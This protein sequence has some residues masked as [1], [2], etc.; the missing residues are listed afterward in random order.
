MLKAPPIQT[1]P[2][3]QVAWPAPGHWTYD[4]YQRLPDDGNRYEVIC[5]VL[6]IMNTPNILHQLAI[7]NLVLEIGS[8]VRRQGLGILLPAP[9]EVILPGIATPAQPDVLFVRAERRHI[10]AEQQVV[11]PPDL[12]IEVLSPSSVRHDRFTKFNAYEEAGIPEYW[13]V[14]PKGRTVEIYQ[15]QEGEYVLAGEYSQDEPLVSPG[16]GNLG[17]AAGVLFQ[18]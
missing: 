8:L 12:V 15:L 4:D 11:G 17:F 7:T 3:R 16:L 2:P 18:S 5:G 1:L 13:I 14:S 6:Y 10:V 9:T